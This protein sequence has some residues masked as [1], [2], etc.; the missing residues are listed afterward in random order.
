MDADAALASAEPDTRSRIVATAERL[1]RQ[2]GYQ[3]TTVADIA[4]ALRMSPANVY[5]FFDSKKAIN[6][7]VAERLM[8]EV[9]GALEVIACQKAPAAVRLRDMIATMHRMNAALY[10]DELRMHEMVER[11]LSE[12]WQVVHGHLERKNAIFQR[13]VGDGME[14]GE[15]APTD[16]V[17]A[18]RCV[19]VALIRFCHPALLVQCA[20]EPGPSLDQMTEFILAGLGWRAVLPAKKRTEPRQSKANSRSV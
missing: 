3:K 19:Q 2:I 5:R 17:I 4:K 13:V 9:E 15:F 1:F 14:T 11:A 18:S 16:P 6:E 8:R 12:S 20:G 10:T 7:V